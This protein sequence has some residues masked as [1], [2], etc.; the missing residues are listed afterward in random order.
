[1]GNWS[2]L[3]AP[4]FIP[5]Q[6]PSLLSSIQEVSGTTEK[7]LKASKTVLQ[8]ASLLASSVNG[9]AVEATLE[10]LLDQ[11]EET[12]TAFTAET[13]A[14][15]IFI[16][17]Q[18]QRF[19]LG[20]IPELSQIPEDDLFDLELDFDS[21]EEMRL[22]NFIR[23]AD[24]AVGGT[25]GFWKALVGST[26]DAGDTHRPEFAEDF[27]VAGNVFLFGSSDMSTLHATFN[28]LNA[29]LR[30][31]SVRNDPSGGTVPTVDDVK[32][33]TIL[34]SSIAPSRVSVVLSWDAVAPIQN[35]PLFTDQ[36]TKVD[37]LLIV[38]STDPKI[39]EKFFWN[40]IFNTQPT[41]TTL[42]KALNTSVIA[43][44][45]ND[46]FVRQ[47]IDDDLSLEAGTT[48][49][50]AIVPRYLIDNKR[51]P[52][53]RLSAVI[54]VE[55]RMPAPTKDSE[56][57]DW[58]S[59]GSIVELVPS[60]EEALGTLSTMMASMRTRTA[61]NSGTVAML[62]QTLTQIEQLLSKISSLNA[63]IAEK[64]TV[65]S[66][67]A[68]TPTLS[69]YNTT[70]AVRTGGLEEWLAEVANCLSD[71][72]DDSR[73]QFAETDLVA[74]FVIVAGAPSLGHLS[75]FLAGLQLFFGNGSSSTVTD[76]VNMVT[77]LA[78]D[79]PAAAEET[80]SSQVAFND[81]LEVVDSAKASC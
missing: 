64:L 5:G 80:S 11:L 8:A 37:E 32:A 7:V 29:V 21:L 66:N 59:T 69:M 49:Y 12:L 40:Q 60:M 41:D 19:G 35:H 61:S 23:L 24:T 56:A 73:P 46:G 30:I 22:H 45:V 77:S 70:V 6:I 1:M 26:R 52:V 4:A 33:R 55:H 18:K 27:A 3:S 62:Q 65:L 47:Y 51:Q 25:A 9:N 75:S 76:A 42:P 20:N 36:A 16:P 67:L 31:N 14:H 81:A 17:I 79:T 44:I 34:N 50:Y 39:R 58:I 28:A 57:P 72:D 68:A 71:P 78:G 63:D 74:G 15:A 43:R 2:T 38:R 10:A 53:S 54:P 48:Y 13:H